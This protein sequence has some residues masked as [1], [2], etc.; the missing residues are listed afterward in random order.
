MFPNADISSQLWVYLN[1]LMLWLKNN[2]LISTDKLTWGFLK[3]TIFCLLRVEYLSIRWW[4]LSFLTRGGLETRIDRYWLVIF[5]CRYWLSMTQVLQNDIHV[6]SKSD[7][8]ITVVAV[9]ANHSKVHVF[10]L[11]CMS[12]K[13]TK[14]QYYIHKWHMCIYLCTFSVKII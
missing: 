2:N 11:S 4:G 13:W 8:T 6:F 12:R 10:R 1:C 5:A 3:P 14:L 7:L 9:G